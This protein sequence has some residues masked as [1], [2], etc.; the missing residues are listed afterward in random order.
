MGIYVDLGNAASKKA[1]NSEIYI[2]KTDLTAVA[3]KK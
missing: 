2:D 3:N 1:L